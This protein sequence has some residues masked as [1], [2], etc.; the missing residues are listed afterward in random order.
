M[1]FIF[2]TIHRSYYVL[3][4]ILSALEKCYSFSV[5]ILIQHKQIL[6]F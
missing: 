4:I 2:L 1:I 6:V 5:K 3:G